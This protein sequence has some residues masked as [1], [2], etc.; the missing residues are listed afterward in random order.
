METKPSDDV[1]LLYQK[2]IHTYNITEIIIIMRNN[3]N[4]EVF[5]AEIIQSNW[6]HFNQVA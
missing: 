5:G 3:T 1:T 2:V 4:K 6:L